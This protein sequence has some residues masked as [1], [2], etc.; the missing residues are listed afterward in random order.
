MDD[1]IKKHKIKIPIF[2]SEVFERESGLF[3][4]ELNLR[5][6]IVHLKN[7]IDSFN[8]NKPLIK[9]PKRNK[10]TET[11]I[12]DINYFDED[13]EETPTLLLKI[14]AFNTNLIDGYFSTPEQKII[15]QKEHEFGSVNN[16]ILVV[17]SIKGLESAKFEYQWKFLIYEDPTKDS[18]ELISICKMLCKNILEIKIKNIKLESVIKDLKKNK[19]LENFEMQIS[20]HYDND[21]TEVSLKNY[22]ISS[23]INTTVYQKYKDVPT[24]I[25]EDILLD[26]KDFSKRIFKFFTNNRE[27][28]ITEEQKD[29]MKTLSTTIE[30]IFNFQIELKEGD[31]ATIFDREFLI[32]QFSKLLKEFAKQT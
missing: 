21:E 18:N 25:F 3:D 28:R 15:L 30:E 29:N 22:L 17:P 27:F 4:D 20:T 24:E 13:F 14:T 23:T 1:N 12:S 26:K 32:T 8:T 19:I 2:T 16:Y 6:M 10:L 9:Q 31:L 11:Q 5:S 7:K